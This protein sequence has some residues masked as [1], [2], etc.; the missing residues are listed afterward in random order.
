M[1]CLCK[2][3]VG[4]HQWTNSADPGPFFP[5][6]LAGLL[7]M[8]EHFT[9]LKRI[10]PKAFQLLDLTWEVLPLMSV[11]TMDRGNTSLNRLQPELPFKPLKSVKMEP[12][13]VFLF[14][15]L[16]KIFGIS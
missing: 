9:D 14:L 4:L 10:N 6:Q 12:V 2:V 3:M 13:I 1:S 8:L 7:A 16:Y 15:L 11:A 5:A